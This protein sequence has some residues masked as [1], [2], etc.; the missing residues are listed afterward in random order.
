M[1]RVKINITMDEALLRRV[2]DYAEVN[3]L[4]RS[5]FISLAM[6]Q[7]LNASDV[8]SAIKELSISMRKIADT[9]E[10]DADT[11]RQLE[12]FERLAR[13]FAPGR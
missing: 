11:Q 8:T 3:Y 10:V 4:N 5:S 12:D 2:D 1:A 7:F 9:G 13:M 6:T